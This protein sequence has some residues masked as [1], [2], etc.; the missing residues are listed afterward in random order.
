MR[1]GKPFRGIDCGEGDP[2]SEQASA[3]ALDAVIV[4][5]G[6]DSFPCVSPGPPNRHGGA[7]RSGV[8]WARLL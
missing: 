4:A 7:R 3:A 1:S 5:D 6:K 8:S 2:D